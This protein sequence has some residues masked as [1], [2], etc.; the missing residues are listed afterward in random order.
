MDFVDLLKGF[1]LQPYDLPSVHQFLLFSHFFYNELVNGQSLKVFLADVCDVF[2]QSLRLFAR[3]SFG[4]V[5]AIKDAH[6]LIVGDDR[7]DHFLIE[8]STV[9]RV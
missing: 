3:W 8:A 7:C 6:F 9:G 5:D 2:E 4:V 1:L